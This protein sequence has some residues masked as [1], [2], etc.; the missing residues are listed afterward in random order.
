VAENMRRIKSKQPRMQKPA[1]S[2]AGGEAGQDGAAEEQQQT[3]EKNKKQTAAER[4]EDKHAAQQ[5]SATKR[6]KRKPAEV[7]EENNEEEEETTTKAAAPRPFKNAATG[8]QRKKKK[9]KPLQSQEII[10]AIK[11]SS[12]EAIVCV[13]SASEDEISQEDADDDAGLDKALPTPV[14]GG[15]FL[16]QESEPDSGAPDKTGSDDET[17]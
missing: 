5:P 4:G 6:K 13:S 17:D 2:D 11:P 8:P 3:T 14:D 15:N 9:A 1:S 10:R 7:E 16:E 12:K